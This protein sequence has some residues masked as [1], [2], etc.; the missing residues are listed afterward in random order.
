MATATAPKLQGKV[1]LL[2]TGDAENVPCWFRYIHH[3][4]TD[5]G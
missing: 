2:V 5:S 1:Q 3:T 4:K